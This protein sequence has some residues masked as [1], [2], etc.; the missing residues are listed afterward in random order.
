MS[1][2]T[3]VEVPCVL[4]SLIKETHSGEDVELTVQLSAESAANVVNIALGLITAWK[5]N[6]FMSGAYKDSFLSLKIDDL[7]EALRAAGVFAAFNKK[8][9]K[10]PYA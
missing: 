4:L 6:Q 8:P 9:T 5:S 1:N 3:Y 10:E 2:K 7:D